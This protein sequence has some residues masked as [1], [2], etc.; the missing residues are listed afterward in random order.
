MT[1]KDQ[2]FLMQ[3]FLS[4][5]ENYS[6]LPSNKSVQGFLVCT[7]NLLWNEIEAIFVYL[8]FFLFFACLSKVWFQKIFLH[9]QIFLTIKTV[10][11]RVYIEE[12][13]LYVGFQ[14]F[15]IKKKNPFSKNRNM[16][17]LFKMQDLNSQLKYNYF[18][19]TILFFFVYQMKFLLFINKFYL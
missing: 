9:L 18:G 15:K 16:K 10:N 8:V 19:N 6:F 7:V 4:K 12:N 1:L 3:I 17:Q 2:L 11:F 13:R 5:N 14:I